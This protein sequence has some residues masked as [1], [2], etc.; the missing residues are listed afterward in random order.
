NVAEVASVGGFVKQYQVVLDPQKL[1]GYGITLDEVIKAINEA[2]Q[3]AGGSVIELGEA[4]Y[5][6]RA[7]G[8]LENL[9][10]FR[11]VPLKSGA[12]GIPVQLGD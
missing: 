5:M 2:N 7:T 10:D 12:T 9:D 3:E 6:V 4:E 11:S 1:A 8:Y